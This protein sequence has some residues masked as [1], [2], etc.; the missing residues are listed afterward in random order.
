MLP[1]LVKLVKLVKAWRAVSQVNLSM[2]RVSVVASGFFPH[3]P[4]SPSPPFIKKQDKENNVIALKTNKQ[5]GG[6]NKRIV[7]NSLE[8]FQPLARLCRFWVSTHKPGSQAKA[9]KS[10]KES[11]RC[12][13]QTDG[14]TVWFDQMAQLNS[15]YSVDVAG[16]ANGLVG[17]SQNPAAGR[18]VPGVPQTASRYSKKNTAT[19]LT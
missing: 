10:S 9:T 12:D 3:S 17:V 4:S 13:A 19:I 8:T 15:H 11:R 14:K 5:T 2:L 7:W 16:G 6:K 18:R 1:P